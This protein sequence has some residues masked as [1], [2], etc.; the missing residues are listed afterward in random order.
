MAVGPLAS[1]AQGANRPV[2]P[3]PVM[4]SHTVAKPE[5]ILSAAAGAAAVTAPDA[6]AQ[7]RLA[8]SNARA[9]ITRDSIY[10]Y[11]PVPPVFAGGMS[12]LGA[13]VGAN[14]RYP[15]A[16][17]QRGVT[18]RVLVQFILGKDGRVQDAHVISGP[19]AGLNEEAYRLVWLMPPWE[20]GR[21]ANGEPVRVNCTLPI[22]FRAAGQ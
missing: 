10:A 2:K 6:A 19:G 17:R 13:Y 20:P 4:A 1:H 9:A 15:E 18:G 8:A 3:G 5:K 11:P 22:T 7:T 12:A 14:M 21:L 16:A